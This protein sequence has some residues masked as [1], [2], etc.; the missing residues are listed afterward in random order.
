MNDLTLPLLVGR[1]GLT[2]TTSGLDG[3]AILLILAVLVGRAGIEGTESGLSEVVSVILLILG[4]LVGLA[5]IMGTDSGVPTLVS[6]ILLILGVLV[7]LAGI[8]SSGSSSVSG[9]LFTLDRRGRGGF[10]GVGSV[11]S[12]SLFSDLILVRRLG[13]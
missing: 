6:G 13:L 9:I 3:S 11:D 10:I 4:V 8:C 12:L 5:G 7:G 1:R 2:G